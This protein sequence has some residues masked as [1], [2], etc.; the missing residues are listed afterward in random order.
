MIFGIGEILMG[1]LCLLMAPL[2]LVGQVMAAKVT[3]ESPN[4]RMAAPSVLFYLG[5]GVVFIWLGIGS[6]KARRWARALSL[7]LAWSWLLMGL[8]SVLMM[9][10]IFPEILRTGGG[11]GQAQIPPAAQ[12]V[13]MTFAFGFLGIFFVLIPGAMAF[14]YRSPHVKATV[15]AMDPVPRWTDACPLPVLAVVLWCMFSA[16]TML[17]MPIGYNGAIPLFGKVITGLPG[18]LIYALFA[19]VLG[20]VAWGL[21]RLRSQAWWVLFIAMLLLAISNAI[22]FAKVDLVAIYAQMGFPQQQV[23]QI[24][25]MN[26]F[27]KTQMIIWT[28]AFMIPIL[29]YLLFIRK[30]LRRTSAL[31]P[32]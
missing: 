13:A 16:V 9:V 29:G 1:G 7:V 3:G 23:E 5:L 17:S 32:A 12:V 20:Y 2:A 21:Y 28:T 31:P 19:A 24:E 27:G 6:L 30:Y 8:A 10:W 25:K 15:E 4:F 26:L 11:G 18:M 22:T 14:F